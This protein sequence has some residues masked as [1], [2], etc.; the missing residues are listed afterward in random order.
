M[1]TMG[2]LYRVLADEV[3]RREELEKI[4]VS[5]QA[6][7]DE[8]KRTAAN[9]Q[10]VQWFSTREASEYI[11]RSIS[12]LTKDRMQKTPLIP[13]QKYGHRTLSYSRTDLDEFIT[14]HKSKK[15]EKKHK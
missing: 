10:V 2:E 12:F 13:F 15:A 3:E 7:L 6:E 11:G 5:Q 1:M 4:V 14:Q 9:I 8:M